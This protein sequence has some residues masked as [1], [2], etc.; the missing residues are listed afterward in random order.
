MRSREEWERYKIE[1]FRNIP[2]EILDLYFLKKN[3]KSNHVVIICE[4][5]E[6]GKF[7]AKML[8]KIKNNKNYYVFENGLHEFK[9]HG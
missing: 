7:A 8:E 5:G 3:I 1:G 6:R 9:D 4:D 2:F